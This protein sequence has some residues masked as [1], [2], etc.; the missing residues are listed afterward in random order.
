MIIAN[1]VFFAGTFFE[2]APKW[3]PVIPLALSLICLFFI[4]TEFL[5]YGETLDPFFPKRTS[6]N[7]VAKYNAT[8]TA[9][10]RI[11]V[12]GHVD[13]SYEWRY[14]YLGGPPLITTVIG[15]AVAGIVIALVAEIYSVATGNTGSLLIDILRWVML[16]WCILFTAAIFFLNYKLPVEGANDNLTGSVASIAVMKYLKDNDIRFEDVEVWTLLTGA[17]EAGL[18]GAKAFAKAHKKELEDMETVFIGVDTLRDYDFYAIYSRDMTFTVKSDPQVCALLKQASL[19]AGLDLPYKAIFLG[20]SDAAAMTQGGAHA[21]TLAAM[22]PGPPKYY[23]TR[24]DK[25]DI[26][27]LKTIEKGVEI[28]L[29]ATFLFDEKGLMKNYD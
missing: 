22:N 6:H 3:L 16:A 4:V 24:D 8:G 19:N 7:V 25:A 12:S 15:G 29:E 17:E 13:S 11:I 2:G 21:T 26:L 18:R 20:A 23:H 1:V 14:T 9:K 10:K 28:A 27:N 5:F